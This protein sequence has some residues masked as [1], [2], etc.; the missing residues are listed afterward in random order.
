MS[1]NDDPLNGDAPIFSGDKTKELH[2][3]RPKQKNKNIG[4]KL[5][6]SF[7][8]SFLIVLFLWIMGH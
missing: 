7:A 5:I 8:I 4:K 3:Y 1:N 6:I 2:T